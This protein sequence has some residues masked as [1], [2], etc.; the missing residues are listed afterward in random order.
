[1]TITYFGFFV[2]LVGGLLLV[3]SRPISLLNFVLI[4]SLMGGSAALIVSSLGGAS[5]QPVSLGLGFLMMSVALPGRGRNSL[6]MDGLRENWALVFFALYGL[7]AA[8][9][10]PRIFAGAMD[11][12]PMNP[13]NISFLFDTFP[14]QFSSQN[15]TTSFYLAGTAAGAV[16]AYVACKALEDHSSLIKIGIAAGALHA[17]L[18]LSDVVLNGTV[19]TQF[20]DFFRN[21]NYAQT[22]HYFGGMP[23]I[24][25]IMPEASAYA[26]MAFVWFVL[27]T[28]FWL[29]RIMP[30]YS[31]VV[32]V[33]LLCALILSLSSTAYAALAAYA[34]LLL[35]RIL[36][37]PGSITASRI[38]ILIWFATVGLATVL[39]LFMFKPLLAQEFTAMIVEL[40]AGKVDSESGQQRLFWVMQ[41]FNAFLQSYG[42]GIGPGS[43]RSSSFIVAILGSMG[44]I[45]IALFVLYCL[46]VFKPLATSTYAV[47]QEA[48]KALGAALS[49]TAMM[50]LVPISVSGPSPD[51]GLLFGLLAGASMGLRERKR[52]G[53][54]QP[55]WGTDFALEGA[56]HPAG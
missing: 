54:T 29:R 32:A 38:F 33:A 53:V 45:G 39:A 17:F 2:A 52:A 46:K 37:V 28:E 27:M 49:W 1:M 4:L 51:P 21:A 3:V 12:V 56:P 10:L 25:G 35:V 5:V 15:I 13:S 36:I 44:I 50:L 6:L 31:G 34:L 40:T 20:L 26:S 41:G 48:K 19:Y 30:V 23:R 8:F 16:C 14:L 11:V 18:G 24:D 7:I 55:R 9:F 22:N 43:F 42:L 47:N